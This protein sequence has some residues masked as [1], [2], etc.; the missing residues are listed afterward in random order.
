VHGIAA[1]AEKPFKPF[2]P[3]FSKP[4]IWA[5]SFPLDFIDTKNV[6]LPCVPL[7]RK[8]I[9]TYSPFISYIYSNTNKYSL[10]V[11]RK[12]LRKAVRPLKSVTQDVEKGSCHAMVNPY[13]V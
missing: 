6:L 9:V 7:K 8:S 4:V 12:W 11:L 10:N 13:M 3:T 1:T 5:G 2:S